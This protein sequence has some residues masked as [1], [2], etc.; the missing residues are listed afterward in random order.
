MVPPI[1]GWAAPGPGEAHRIVAVDDGPPENIGSLT[2][3]PRAAADSASQ[4][5]EPWAAHKTK[6]PQ[7][8]PGPETLGPAAYRG[9]GACSQRPSR[10][11]RRLAG[12]A[13]PSSQPTWPVSD[14]TV[15]GRRR[16]GRGPADGRESRIARSSPVIARPSRFATV[17]VI[18]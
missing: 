1:D 13:R 6:S 18:E 5:N 11:S 3:Y 14:Q 2:A 15:V 12:A 8:R 9:P 17:L 7:I 16:G 10:Q 4:T